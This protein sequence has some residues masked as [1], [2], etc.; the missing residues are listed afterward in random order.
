MITEN[1]EE[2][3]SRSSEGKLLADERDAM[4]E[5]YYVIGTRCSS[6]QRGERGLRRVQKE[7]SAHGN[8][9]VRS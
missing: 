8:R 2:N 3:G 1:K 4:K 6:Y 5:T 7:N 9:V